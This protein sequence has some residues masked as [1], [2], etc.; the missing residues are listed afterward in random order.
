MTDHANDGSGDELTMRLRVVLPDAVLIDMRAIK[1]VAEAVNGCFAMLPRHIDFVAPLVAGLIL[2]TDETGNETI[3]GTDEGTLVKCADDVMVATRRA[4]LGDD[5]DT[6]RR[7]IETRFRSL[8]EHEQ[9]T[10]RALAQL[11]S[12]IVRRFVELEEKQ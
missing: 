9:S 4:V 6:L 1:V 5:L 12:G 11:E 2:V 3:V 8:D 7:T 10:R